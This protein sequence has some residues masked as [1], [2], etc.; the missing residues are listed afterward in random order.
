MMIFGGL[1]GSPVISVLSALYLRVASYKHRS[2]ASRI[3][4]YGR[5]ANTGIDSAQLH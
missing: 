2:T 1:A 5:A 3:E 4:L